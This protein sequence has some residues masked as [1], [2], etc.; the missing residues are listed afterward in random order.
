MVDGVEGCA[1]LVIPRAARESAGLDFFAE[2]GDEGASDVDEAV[3]ACFRK[4]LLNVF[5]GSE[6]G[7]IA[8]ESKSDTSGV[9]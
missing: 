3:L 8:G 7:R 6:I 4:K 9:A 1:G 5:T 2:G